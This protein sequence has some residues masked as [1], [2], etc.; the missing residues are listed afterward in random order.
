MIVTSASCARAFAAASS[1]STCTTGRISI[2]NSARLTRASNSPAMRKA[3]SAADR[4]SCT[5]PQDFH[6]DC[7]RRVAPRYINTGCTRMGLAHES[8]GFSGS[9]RSAAHGVAG[10]AAMIPGANNVALAINAPDTPRNSRR[11]MHLQH[12]AYPPVVS[13]P[14]KTCTFILNQPRL[15]RHPFVALLCPSAA[16]TH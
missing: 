4:A 13:S 16:K 3:S 11:L 10:A 5:S 14:R 9:H 8:S 1:E 15:H 12:M 2:G 6:D 7:S